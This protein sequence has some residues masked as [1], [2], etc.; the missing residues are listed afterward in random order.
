MFI[1]DRTTIV[2]MCENIKNNK[3]AH[4]YDGAYEVVKKAF[5]LKNN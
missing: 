2:E 1:K 3:K 5:E 4:I